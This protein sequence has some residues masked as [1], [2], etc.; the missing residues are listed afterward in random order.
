M[1]F[2]DG[3]DGQRKC[4]VAAN[5]LSAHSEE[6]EWPAKILNGKQNEFWLNIG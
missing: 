4:I 2:I 3:P 5:R 6:P 1:H